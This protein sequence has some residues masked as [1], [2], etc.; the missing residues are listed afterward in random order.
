[1]IN[2]RLGPV[3]SGPD[4]RKTHVLSQ[5]R[6]A[7]HAARRSV[8]ALAADRQNYMESDADHVELQLARGSA[9]GFEQAMFRKTAR[10]QQRRRTGG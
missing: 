1:M 2:S 9:K 3:I 8:R 6:V 10:L 4:L 7:E 5:I